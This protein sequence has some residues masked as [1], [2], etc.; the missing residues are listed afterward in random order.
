MSSDTLPF[1][2][3]AVVIGASAGGVQALQL[4][5]GALPVE[6]AIDKQP[7]RPG[8]ETA[9]KSLSS[10]CSSANAATVEAKSSET[11]SELIS[12]SA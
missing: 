3:E 2:P 12:G 6:E 4:L 9:Q 8:S 1:R 5:L 10:S 11:A 7:L